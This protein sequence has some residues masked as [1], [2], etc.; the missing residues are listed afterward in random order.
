MQC[1]VPDEWIPGAGNVMCEL[2]A[3]NQRQVW[4]SAI[5]HGQLWKQ[6]QLYSNFLVSLVCVLSFEFVATICFKIHFS[7]K[8]SFNGR[9]CIL[10]MEHSLSI[11]GR[12]V[13]NFSQYFAGNCT[14]TYRAVK[15][16]SRNFTVYQ[17][18]ETRTKLALA[19]GLV[20]NLADTLNQLN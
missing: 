20:N 9:V 2:E 7:E 8:W 5:R 16:T 4:A 15:L 13:Q 14:Q 17:D 3:A 1:P 19:I 11:F 18:Q 10:K 6:W 12:V